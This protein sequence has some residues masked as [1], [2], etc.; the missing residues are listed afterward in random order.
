MNISAVDNVKITGECIV[1]IHDAKTGKLKSYDHIKNL[2]V[3]SGKVSIASS[4]AGIRNNHQGE[5]TYCAV[6]TGTDAPLAANTLL[7]IELYRKQISV[8]SASGKTAIFKTF[9]NQSEANGLLK[10]AGLFGE[11][12]TATA[13]TGTLFCRLNINRTKS[14]NDTLT[15]TWMVTVGV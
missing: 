5:I 6:G 10:E 15:L 12:A 7:Q 3:D 11:A 1:E 4:L 2:V 9:F 14:S 8:R 13:D